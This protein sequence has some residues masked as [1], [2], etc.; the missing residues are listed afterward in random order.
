[1]PVIAYRDA[2]N[3]AI[4]E[5]MARDKRVILIGEEVA[6][7]NGA[8]KVSRGLHDKYG[9]RRVIDTPISEEGFTGIGIGAAMAGLR[10]IVEWM[11]FNFSIQALDQV[12]NNAAKMRYMSGGQFAIPIVFRGPNGPAEWLSSQHSQALASIYT[13]VPGLKVVSAATPY[14]AKGLLKTAIRDDNP[15]VMM[16]AELL[17]GIKGD[18]P[19][20]EYLISLG[21]ADIKRPGRDVTLITFGKVVHMVLEA[22]ETLAQDDIDAE[23]IDLRSLR[24]LDEAAIVASVTKTSRCVVIDESWP[25]ASVGSHV[26]WLVSHR[27][28]DRL[29]AQVELVAGEDIPMPYNHQLELAAQPSVEKILAAVERVLYL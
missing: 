29:D 27:C 15:V 3:Q 8:Y 16:E 21:K 12:I 6:L 17:Y 10:P 28:F 4:D 22:A 7:Y 1:M 20:D 11:T 18:V 19:A 23:V 5:E 9:D 2:L 14:D 24:P 25:V 26:A 13:H